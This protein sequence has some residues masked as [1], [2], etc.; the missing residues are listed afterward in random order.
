M[1]D[2]SNAFLTENVTTETTDKINTSNPL[3]TIAV[4]Y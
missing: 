4:F 2:L 3:I 1:E